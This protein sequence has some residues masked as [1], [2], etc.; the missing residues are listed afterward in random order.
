MSMI[1]VNS[2]IYTETAKQQ[3]NVYDVASSV[4]YTAN[5]VKLD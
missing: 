1:L 3:D 5:K 4:L 2:Y